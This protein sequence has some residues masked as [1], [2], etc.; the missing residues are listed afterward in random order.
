MDD[1][2]SNG[3]ILRHFK[4]QWNDA[5]DNA[6]NK[7][8]YQVIC[9][10]ATSTEDKEPVVVYQALY[11]PFKVWVRPLSMFFEPIDTNKYPKADL[12]YQDTRFKIIDINDYHTSL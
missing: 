4:A 8:L 6:T 1:K 5:H 9:A 7:Y 3:Q 12:S 11:S 10:N 2:L